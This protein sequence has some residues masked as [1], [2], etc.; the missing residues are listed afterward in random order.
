LTPHVTKEAAAQRQIDAAI[1]ILFSGEDILA[2]HSIA[3]AARG[4]LRALADKRGIERR[5]TLKAI[6]EMYRRHHKVDPDN[7]EV[8]AEI[9]RR[10][11]SI[12]KWRYDQRNSTSNFLKHAD[13]DPHASLPVEKVDTDFVIAEA[14]NYYLLLGLPLTTE[15][16][17][18]LY[19]FCAMT[20]SRPE[21]VLETKL[22][23][24]HKLPRLQQLELANALLQFACKSSRS[25]PAGI[26]G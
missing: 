20:A 5:E 14:C 17:V 25:A 6:R 9:Q 22:G 18:F 15:M 11:S 2:V 23:P 26:R 3:A 13:R 10:L 12:Q 21:E 19:W 4:I 16:F 24:L 7:P 8:S 1:R